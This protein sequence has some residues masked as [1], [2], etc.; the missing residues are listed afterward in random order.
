MELWCL[1][2]VWFKTYVVFAIKFLLK[3]TFK[4]YLPHPKIKFCD[5]SIE[6]VNC[7]EYCQY[8]F[9]NNNDN[10][11]LDL[12]DFM[13]EQWNSVSITHNRGQF[14]TI[15]L[16]RHLLIEKSLTPESVMNGNKILALMIPEVDV[17]IIDSY[18]FLSMK[19]SKFPE[20]LGIKDLRKG[21]HPYSFTDLNYVGPMICEQYFDLRSEK[22][23]LEEFK[24]WYKKR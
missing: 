15:F 7:C 17:K 10:V 22:K 9:E 2:I 21:F 23:G 4:F 19:L 18:S 1:F 20:A 3:K 24:T 14:D 8:V 11:L 5:I 6:P 12:V 13:L 16:L